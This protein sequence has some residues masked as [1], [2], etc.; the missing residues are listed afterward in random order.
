MMPMVA[1]SGR[2]YPSGT[3]G[4][5]DM[6]CPVM[7]ARPC[8]DEERHRAGAWGESAIASKSERQR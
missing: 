3:S 6:S 2:Q 1:K 4:M 8:T 5:A 7:A